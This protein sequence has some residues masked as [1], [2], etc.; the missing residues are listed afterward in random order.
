NVSADGSTVVGRSAST[1]APSSYEAFRWTKAGGMEGLGDLGTAFVDSWAQAVSA[2]GS[3]VAG[4]GTPDSGVSLP[5]RWTEGTGLVALVDSSGRMTRGQA[6]DISDD[7]SVIVGVGS[8]PGP[9]QG[10]RWTATTGMVGL[11]WLPAAFQDSFAFGTSGDGGVVCGIS[12]SGPGSDVE[13]FRWTA[14]TG[15]VGMGDVPGGIFYAIAWDVSADG[16][17]ICGAAR[18]SFGN[19]EIFVWT[20]AGGF[21]LPDATHGASGGSSG[22]AVSAD[23]SVVVGYGPG[24]PMIRDSAHGMRRLDDLL[25][26]LGVDL[27]GWQL[28]VASGVSADGRTIC[29]NGMNPDGHQEAWIARLPEA[30]AS[31]APAPQLG[32]AVL[33]A[34]GPNPF[35]AR[36]AFRL[37]LPPGG[38]RVRAT[39]HG[40]DGST[41]RVL[42][43][44]VL[45]SGTNVIG[46]DGRSDRGTPVAGGVYLLRINAGAQRFVRKLVLLR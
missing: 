42:V 9:N 44:D 23:G 20:E 37:A 35:P 46:W 14:A 33:A 8:S 21:V 31:P 6:F 13:T 5:F 30:T 12:F 15:L 39:V 43:D 3:V 17:T 41:H 22:E 36:T 24:G 45:P 29:G 7:G 34:A 27:T 40:I 26:G 1:D 25:A 10:F 18:T 32:R 28:G 16:S 38:A 19:D 4:E 11:G 2:D